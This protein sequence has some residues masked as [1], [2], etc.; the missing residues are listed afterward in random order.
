V[1]NKDASQLRFLPAFL[2]VWS[3]GHHGLLRQPEN[4]LGYGAQENLLWAGAPMRPHDDEID[5]MFLDQ[6]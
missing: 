5:F 4:L 2:H 1:G 3:D 6:A